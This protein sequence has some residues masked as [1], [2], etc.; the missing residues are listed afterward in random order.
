MTD[1]QRMH[2]DE[3]FQAIDQT[4][5]GIRANAHAKILIVGCR[6]DNFP[7]PYKSHPQLVFRDSAF[8]F[9][10]QV[11]QAVRL[12]LV[13]RFIKHHQYAKLA[14]ISQSRSIH[15]HK[16]TL[17]T[18]EVKRLL[19]PLIGRT[20][21]TDRAVAMA[22]E[23]E[24]I[25]VA[26]PVT[27]IMAPAVPDRAKVAKAN[28][29]PTEL[30]PIRLYGNGGL[31]EFVTK[32]AN[33]TFEPRFK[34]GQRLEQ[35]ARDMG[36]DTTARSIEQAMYTVR[37]RVLETVRK[38]GTPSTLTAA[39]IAQTA[40]KPVETT[41][42]PM[43]KAASLGDDDA[44]LLAMIDDAERALRDVAA[45]VDL[46]RQTIAGRA[47]QRARLKAQVKALQEQL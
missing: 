4:V 30:K 32:F 26:K 10:D 42:A 31:R 38:S 47:E 46:L 27:T 22:T 2:G 34:E 3:S 45:T 15:M 44:A 40:P 18:G 14:S 43:V 5:A 41:A 36:Y 12:I 33:L 25:A 21:D 9:T 39:D 19:A 28:M 13:T 23:K 6:G 35:M 16:G 11:P 7:E 8:G 29:K 1:V 17:G 24:K 37:K 20:I